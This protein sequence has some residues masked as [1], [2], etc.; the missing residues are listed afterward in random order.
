MCLNILV[1]CDFE[2]T[3]CDW[4]LVTDKSL[5]RRSSFKDHTI[6][7]FHGSVSNC[8]RVFDGAIYTQFNWMIVKMSNI[9]DRILEVTNNFQVR[10]SI[11]QLQ[12]TLS[13]GNSFVQNDE[14]L[15]SNE[16]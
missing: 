8:V 5:H 2:N 14:L 7:G 4:T 16:Y 3:T 13:K 9:T 1:D 10:L 15:T 11:S 6:C 12:N